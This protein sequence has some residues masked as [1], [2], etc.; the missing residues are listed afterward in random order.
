MMEQMDP[1]AFGKRSELSVEDIHIMK[2]LKLKN[3]SVFTPS[4]KSLFFNIF[5]NL[6]NYRS[7]NEPIRSD[8]KTT[9]SA[10]FRI[11]VAGHECATSYFLNNLPLKPTKS[12]MYTSITKNDVIVQ[13]SSLH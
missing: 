10:T 12:P 8:S 5:L 13:S 3:P 11:K 9:E 6:I 4:K 2:K 1:F 7:N